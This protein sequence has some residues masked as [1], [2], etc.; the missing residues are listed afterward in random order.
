MLEQGL[1]GR[2]LILHSHSFFMKILLLFYP[3]PNFGES[4]FL[5]AVKSWILHHFLLKS[6]IL[7]IPFQT[8]LEGNR[9]L[10]GLGLQ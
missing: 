6:R 5:G 3:V 4:R 10:I 7:W 1:E 9:V 8:L 2:F